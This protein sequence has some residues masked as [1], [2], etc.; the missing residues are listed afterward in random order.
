MSESSSSATYAGGRICWDA[1]SHL[2]EEPDFLTRH[3]DAKLH[4]ALHIDGGANGGAAFEQRFGEMLA[5]VRSRM[6]SPEQTRALEDNVIAS[7]KGWFAHG[8]VDGRERSRTLDLLGFKGQLVF[9]TFAGHFLASRDP[10][11]VYGG[12][13][14]HTRAMLDFCGEDPRLMAVALIPLQDPARAIEELEFALESGARAVH[15]PSDPP[16]GFSGGFAP[17][18]VDLEPFWARLAEA[19]VPVVL[20]I[21]GGKL[22]PR[23]YHNNGRPQ[24]T[25]WLGGGEN[26]RG[27]DFPAVH[28]SPENF[29]TTVVLDGVLQRH[30]DLRLAAIELGAS[31]VPG[32]L[33]NLDAA[34]NTFRKTEPLLQALELKPSEYIQRQARFTPFPF[35]DVG[36]L[37]EDSG[38]D[39]FLF[40]SDYPH[41]EG[42]RNPIQR[43]E[44]SFDEAG[45]SDFARERFYSR[46]FVDLFQIEA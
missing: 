33:R 42:G 30:P 20:H 18:H 46:N 2:M 45:T 17:S 1:D 13:R 35:E 6:A 25:D 22:I 29:I 3:A 23:A 27:K 16:G 34:W 36:W 26:L 10:E 40:S 14:A 41:P 9:S 11:I 43:F 7:A 19:R 5:K 21:G 28:H 38:E 31:W 15:V 8:A 12:T 24:P 4:D 32:M 37:I 44:S 39:L